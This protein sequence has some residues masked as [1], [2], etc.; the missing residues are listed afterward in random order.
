MYVVGTWDNN[1]QWVIT[2]LGCTMGKLTFCYVTYYIYVYSKP[3][4]FIYIQRE[5]AVTLF[6]YAIIIRSTIYLCNY[7]WKNVCF[8]VLPA[9]CRMFIHWASILELTMLDWVDRHHISLNTYIETS[10]RSRLQR[11]LYICIY[12]FC[13]L[14][15]IGFFHSIV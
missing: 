10:H 9:V 2:L 4:F 12:I 7:I 15:G 1:F 3:S 11:K 13:M 14:A 8:W 6:I 5:G